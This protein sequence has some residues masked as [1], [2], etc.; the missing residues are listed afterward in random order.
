MFPFTHIHT[1]YYHNATRTI[2]ASIVTMFY[3]VS[4]ETKCEKKNETVGRESWPLVIGLAGK[5]LTSPPTLGPNHTKSFIHTYSCWE[6]GGIYTLKYS[7]R[8]PNYGYCRQEYG[9]GIVWPKSVSLNGL[10]APCQKHPAF[11]YAN[12][13]GLLWWVISVW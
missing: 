8:S 13:C 12:S 11:W 3:Y 6:Y 5:T 1:R 2:Q 7:Q 10:R 9:S 4:T